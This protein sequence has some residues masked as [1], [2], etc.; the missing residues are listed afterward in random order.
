MMPA[1]IEI[2]E[3][4]DPNKFKMLQAMTLEQKY[5]F[6]ELAINS[7]ISIHT[8]KTLIS[9]LRED[10]NFIFKGEIHHLAKHQISKI[11]FSYILREGER[12]NDDYYFPPD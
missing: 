10:I 1:T 3:K 5:T 2:T 8:I 11:S 9:S 7:G 4:S 12:A 6:Q